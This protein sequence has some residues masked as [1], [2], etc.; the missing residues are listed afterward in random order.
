MNGYPADWKFKKKDNMNTAYNVHTKNA[1]SNMP[2]RMRDN[3][4]MLDRMVAGD[5]PRA[6]YMTDE[7][8]G[9]ILGMINKEPTQSG[10][11]VNMAGIT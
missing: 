11:M 7:Q 2:P 9:N 10:I 8:H 3:G 4:E 6:P 1:Q 5:L